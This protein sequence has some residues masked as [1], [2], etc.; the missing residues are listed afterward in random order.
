PIVE[1]GKPK[2]QI[3]KIKLASVLQ[4]NITARARG[5]SYSRI[6]MQTENDTVDCLQY[7]IEQAIDQRD[8]GEVGDIFPLESAAALLCE[9]VR[10]RAYEKRV[11]TLVFNRTTWAVG[12][13]T[14]H[15]ATNEWDDPDNATPYDDVNKAIEQIRLNLG[16]SRGNAAVMS[17][18]TFRYLCQTKQIRDSVGGVKYQQVMSDK[19]GL[20]E[21]QRVAD[22]LGLD[23]IIVGGG[24][25]NTA[26]LN[27][28][29]SVSDIWD[30]EYC[31][32][33]RKG[34]PISARQ[35]N[36]PTLGL[37]FCATADGFAGSGMVLTYQE[38]QTDSYVV[39][40]DEDKHEKILYTGAGYLIGNLKT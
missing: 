36:D 30:P 11:A 9:S 24:V 6:N 33:F 10:K 13:T 14:G 16:G 5:T 19:N 2:A 39:R 37:T 17:I 29:P 1:I 28:T 8:I 22:L 20:L 15:D 25:K 18:R 40:S 12:T 34:V 4:D 31:M 21:T 26:N 7:P 32:V 38:Q 23:E 27:Q 35:I 3:S